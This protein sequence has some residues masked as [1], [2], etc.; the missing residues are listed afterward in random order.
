MNINEII[1]VIKDSLKH[2][3]NMGIFYINRTDDRVVVRIDEGNNTP[4]NTFV[5]DNIEDNYIEVLIQRIKDEI[6]NKRDHM[7]LYGDN[8]SNGPV[9]DFFVF[10]DHAN[11]KIEIFSNKDYELLKQVYEDYQKENNGEIARRR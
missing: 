9:L 7:V 2:S 5:L 8:E 4:H 3:K 11:K 6:I 10:G 1:A